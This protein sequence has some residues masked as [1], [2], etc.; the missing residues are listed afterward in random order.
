MDR[1]GAETQS[2][3]DFVILNGTVIDAL[4]GQFRAFPPH[5]RGSSSDGE[6]RTDRG[7]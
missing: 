3:D 5:G 4:Y 7:P 6:R 1:S 2:A